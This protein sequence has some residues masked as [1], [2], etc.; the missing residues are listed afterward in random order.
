MTSIYQ[1]DPRQD[2]T[3]DGLTL[4]FV[5]GQCK[6]DKGL[7]NAVI[8]TLFYDPWFLNIEITD[9]VYHI[10]SDFLKYVQRPITIANLALA[11]AA[12]LKALQWM[13]TAG[14]ASE[15]DVRLRNPSGSIVEVLVLIKPPAKTKIALLATRYG[16]NW[17]FQ[18]DEG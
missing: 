12:G 16:L 15:I 4:S 7:V 3:R 14:V 6:M 11:R 2:I 8:N 1:G 10:G 13:I 9:D 18:I 5:D 17:E